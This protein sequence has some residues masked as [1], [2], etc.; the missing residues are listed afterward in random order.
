VLPG[1]PRGFSFP[2]A[3][4]V[5]PRLTEI[6]M[7][8]RVL[9][10]LKRVR[11]DVGFREVGDGITPRLVQEDDVFAVSDPVIESNAHAPPERFGEWQSLG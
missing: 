11:S 8:A 3:D 9:A 5:P 2:G 4:D 10:W 1:A 7:L 6:P